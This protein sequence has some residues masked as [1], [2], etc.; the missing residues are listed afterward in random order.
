MVTG[1]WLV[2]HAE[3]LDIH[4]V[5]LD[6]QFWSAHIARGQWHEYEAPAPANEILRHLDH[7]HVDVRGG[8]SS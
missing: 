5:I 8:T 2:A 6:A 1:A 3:D 4:Y 7:V